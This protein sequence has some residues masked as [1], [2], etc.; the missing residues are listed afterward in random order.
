[1][2]PVPKDKALLARFWFMSPVPKFNVLL[3]FQDLI[4]H[5]HIC[6]SDLIY[7]NALKNTWRK[8]R[9]CSVYCLVDASCVS[10]K[11]TDILPDSPRKKD[12]GVKRK[13]NSSFPRFIASSCTRTYLSYTARIALQFALFPSADKGVPAREA[14]SYKW[15]RKWWDFEDP[16]AVA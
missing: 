5:I 2:S 13:L 7:R 6:V 9:L 4:T 14:G 3:A 15:R 11:G 1:M 10:Y 16:T 8:T 12:E